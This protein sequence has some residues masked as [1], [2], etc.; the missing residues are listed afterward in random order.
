MQTLRTFDGWEV[1]LRPSGFGRFFAAAFLGFWLC[2]WAVGETVV[3]AILLGAGWTWLTG[4]PPHPDFPNIS[5]AARLPVGGFLLLWLTFWTYGGI[6]ALWTFLRTLWGEDRIMVRGDLL[7]VEQ[8][9][10]PLRRTREIPRDQIRGIHR[11]RSRSLHPSLIAD[12]LRGPI[13]LT[14]FLPAADLDALETELRRELN[15]Q[16]LTAASLPQG[17]EQIAVPEGGTVLVQSPARRRRNGLLVALA[18][19]ALALTA[20]WSA[21]THQPI[22]AVVC[23]ALAALLGWG[24][25][26]LLF[27][28]YEWRWARGRLRRDWRCRGHVRTLCEGNRLRLA[29]SSD[30]DNDDWYSL[31]LLD[32]TATQPNKRRPTHIAHVIRDPSLPRALGEWLARESGLP[33][34]DALPSATTRAVD[35][36][37]LRRKLEASGQLGRWMAKF[38]QPAKTKP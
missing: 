16:T 32:D 15:L 21:G 23:T 9:A 19:A 22:A 14:A 13:P 31:D 38:V 2:G 25:W 6:T 27:G 34:E 35:V 36:E 17:W 1:R 10:A 26:R 8:R 28:R 29:A 12:T 11:L 4:T 3:L 18:A 24:A 20:L 33:L 5:D 7:R 37:E 30:S